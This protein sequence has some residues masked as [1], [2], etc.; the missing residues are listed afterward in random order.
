MKENALQ[1]NQM[2]PVMLPYNPTVRLDKNLPFHYLTFKE[3]Y[4][5]DDTGLFVLQLSY[6]A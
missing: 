2:I 3:Q 6:L 5:S 4:S 1:S